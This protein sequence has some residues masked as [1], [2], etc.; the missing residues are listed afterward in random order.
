MKP[1][2]HPST[3]D[4]VLYLTSAAFRALLV[5]TDAV[6]RLGDIRQVCHIIVY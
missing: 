1:Q 6:H 4:N 5:A 3:D 2:F